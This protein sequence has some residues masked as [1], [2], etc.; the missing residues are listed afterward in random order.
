MLQALDTVT[1]TRGSHLL[2]AGIDFR[3]VAQDAFR[4][5]QS[6]GFL[7]FTSQAPITGNALADLLLGI[8]A[9]T[10]GARL[11]N[12]QHLRTRSLNLFV[13]DSMRLHPTFTVTAGVR[14]EVN[15]PPVDADDRATLYD[16]ATGSLV[17]V[18][19]GGLPRGGYDTDRNNLAPRLGVAWTPAGWDRVVLRG[20][21]GLYFDQSALAS[22]E[23]LYFSPPYYDL[24]FY[25]SLPDAPITLADPFPADYPLPTPDSALAIQRDLQTG[26]L[27]HFSA[28]VQWQLGDRRAIEAAY[29]GSR[30]RDLVG[31]RDINQPAPSA[32]PLNLRP[33]PRFADITL[34]ES[35]ASSAYDSLQVSFTQ[36]LQAGVAVLASYTLSESVDDVSSFFASAGDANFPQDSRNPEAERARSN[37]D[38]RHRVSIAASCALPLGVGRAWLN[39]GGWLSAVFG[40]WDVE[41]LIALQSGRPFTVALLPEI[42]NSNTGRASLGFGSNDRPNQVGDP[43]LSDP[44]PDA[45]FDPAAFA[46][47]PFGSFGD[48]GR[49]TLEGPGYQNVNLALLRELPLGASRLQLRVEAFNLFNHVNFDLPDN[50]LGSP[51]FGRILSA[52]SPRRIQ[53]GTRVIW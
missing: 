6:R 27:H 49:N 7:T 15:T 14:Y 28:G 11:D 22:S 13:H 32:A 39:D 35:R 50:F 34:I 40:G 38:V 46:F 36:R 9:L 23:G 17:Q 10:G 21:Y 18:G 25:F 29:V 3:M 19:T 41:A 20:G 31:A 37:F 16:Q 44:G 26:A 30:G 43:S 2:K 33:D 51:T 24:S 5:V 12:P 53:F 48:V 52:G 1:F 8:P 47:P 42:D 4:D 45:W